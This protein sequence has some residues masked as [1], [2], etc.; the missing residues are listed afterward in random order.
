MLKNT[1]SIKPHK[2]KQ[3]VAHLTLSKRKK[4]Q[5]SL[6]AKINI[7]AIATALNRSPSTISR[8]VQRN[9]SKRYYKAVNANNQANKIAKKPKPCLLNQNLPLQKLVLKKLKIK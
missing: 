9:Q 1:S 5:A 2:R 8:K 7:R 3:A 4:I 6:S